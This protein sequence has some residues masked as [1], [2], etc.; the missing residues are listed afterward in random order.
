MASIDWA[1]TNARPDENH[2]S[3][4][5]WCVYIRD[6]TVN[7]IQPSSAGL[8]YIR[9]PNMVITVPTDG[10]A[11]N[12]ARPSAGTVLTTERKFS[13]FFQLSG[14]Q[15]CFHWSEHLIQNGPQDLAKY[16]STLSI[17]EKQNQLCQMKLWEIFLT[18]QCGI[19]STNFM[20]IEW[21]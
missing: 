4:G 11:P 3:F 16:R 20:I 21:R 19:N 1:K 12:G 15:I 14:L 5:I 9:D 13:P 18:S 7:I 2:L 17:N 6:F 10:L 8:V